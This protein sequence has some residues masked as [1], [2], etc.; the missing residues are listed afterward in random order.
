MIVLIVAC[1]VGFWVAVLGG[2]TLRSVA[3]MPRTGAAVLLLAPVLD[4]VLLVATAIDLRAGGAATWEHGLAALYIGFSV[5]YGH[6]MM[7]WADRH[8]ARIRTGQA[9]PAKPVGWAHTRKCWGDV[10]RTTLAAVLS[11][12]VL[13]GLIAWG[14]PGTAG[15]EPLLGWFPVLGVVVAVELLWALGYTVWPKRATSA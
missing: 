1:E 8:L 5:T 4:A 2:L 3:G 7:R 12:A 9:L 14:G 15:V 10:V 6:R 11:A 13:G